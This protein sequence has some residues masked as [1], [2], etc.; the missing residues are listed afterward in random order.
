MLQEV[1][2]SRL[3]ASNSVGSY[4]SAFSIPYSDG[5]LIGAYC[6]SSSVSGA[7][8]LVTS[9]L[10]ELKAIATS[11]VDVSKA[12]NKI[13]LSNMVALEGGNSAADVML[14]AHAQ[15][16]ET[17]EYADVRNVSA[18][19]VSEAAATMLKS[20]PAVAVL[21]STYGL[22]SFDSIKAAMQ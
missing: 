21:G 15:G 7:E 22:T 9:V 2:A 3:K 5:G 1:L 4:A 12:A 8:S 17:M 6:A 14:A 20:N 19:D 10:K 18:K 13:T 11:S 16:L